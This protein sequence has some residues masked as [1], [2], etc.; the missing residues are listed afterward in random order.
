MIKTPRKPVT[1]M[2]FCLNCCNENNVKKISISM[3]NIDHLFRMVSEIIEADSSHLFLL[4]DGTRIDD[5]KYLEGL[6]YN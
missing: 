2:Y 6:E 5:N 3:K 4:S 1:L